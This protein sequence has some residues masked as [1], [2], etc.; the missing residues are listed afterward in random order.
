MTTHSFEMVIPDRQEFVG[1]GPCG[2]DISMGSLMVLVS[3]APVSTLCACTF[4]SKLVCISLLCL[5]GTK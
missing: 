4:D 1:E 5:E 2:W 3:Q